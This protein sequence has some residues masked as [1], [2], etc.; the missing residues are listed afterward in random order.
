MTFKGV[1][2]RGFFQVTKVKVAHIISTVAPRVTP[3]FAES[4]FAESHFAESHFAESH[5]A[6][7]HFAESR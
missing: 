2:P 7:S 6:E 3:H 5:F 1:F 4:H